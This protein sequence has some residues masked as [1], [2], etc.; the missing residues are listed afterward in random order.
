MRI[1]DLLVST[2]QA[3]SRKAA[4]RLIEGGAVWVYDNRDSPP[5]KV[6][7]IS[8]NI[9]LTEGKIIKAGREFRQIEVAG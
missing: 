7:S 3:E 5:V 2:G 6:S 9:E 1:Q 8:Q 4:Q